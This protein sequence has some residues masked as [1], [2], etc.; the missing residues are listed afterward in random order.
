M[1]NH[2]DKIKNTIYKS[3]IEIDYAIRYQSVEKL[4]LKWNFQFI[5]F[6][7][8]PPPKTYCGGVINGILII[9]LE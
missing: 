4:I 3:E 9:S 8:P 7:P 1:I 6:P 5:V 2:V